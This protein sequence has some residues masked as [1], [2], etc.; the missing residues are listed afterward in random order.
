ME[1]NKIDVEEMVRKSIGNGKVIIIDDPIK[2]QKNKWEIRIEDETGKQELIPFDNYHEAQEACLIFGGNNI[3]T[4]AA[5]SEFLDF[6]NWSYDL[7]FSLGHYLKKITF[8]KSTSSTDTNREIP[9]ELPLEHGISHLPGS[10]KAHENIVFKEVLKT[11]NYV[12][13]KTIYFDKPED[14]DSFKDWL[15]SKFQCH[16]FLVKSF[17]VQ[18]H[19]TND[20]CR[21]EKKKV[22]DSTKRMELKLVKLNGKPYQKCRISEI[23]SAADGLAEHQC[24]VVNIENNIVKK[25]DHC[26]DYLDLISR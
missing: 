10:R 11:V 25:E 14:I 13:E 18:H 2:N 22:G 23:R 12:K 20:F 19:E 17:T 1:I 6:K 16:T 3:F 9:Y 4:I 5:P 26:G 8:M 24:K 21:Y 7:L 15:Y